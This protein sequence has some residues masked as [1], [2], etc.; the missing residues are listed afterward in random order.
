MPIGSRSVLKFLDAWEQPQQV[1]VTGLCGSL[2]SRCLIGSAVLYKHCISADPQDSPRSCSL[3]LGDRLSARLPNPL[4]QVTALTSDRVI[5]KAQEKRDLAQ[6][7]T[8]DVVDMEGFAVLERLQQ[9]G[10]EVAM[11]RVVS[12]NCL[13][14]LPDLTRALSPDGALLPRQMAIELLKSP[15]AATR[16]IRGSLKGLRVLEHLIYQLF[17]HDRE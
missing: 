2:D 14:D 15:I 16:L 12:D 3:S 5:H 13:H 4:P 11:L 8:A 7:Y 17:D 1:L 10:A 6:T 9:A